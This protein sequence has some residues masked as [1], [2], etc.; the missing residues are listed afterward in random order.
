MF[1]PSL[2]SPCLCI[3]SFL[4][5]LFSRFVDAV[6]LQ[7]ALWD[8]FSRLVPFFLEENRPRWRGVNENDVPEKSHFWLLYFP[9]IVLCIEK[10]KWMDGWRGKVFRIFHLAVSIVKNFALAQQCVLNTARKH[11]ENE[12]TVIGIVLFVISAAARGRRKNAFVRKY[13]CLQQRSITSPRR[14]ATAEERWREIVR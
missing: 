7:F 11:G 6:F 13:E 14:R 9:S 2:T 1:F 10:K 4:F 5:S 8:A 12:N 3:S